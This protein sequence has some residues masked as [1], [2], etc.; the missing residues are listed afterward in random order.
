[1]EEKTLEAPIAGETQ[2]DSVDQVES[3]I[4]TATNI[5]LY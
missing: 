5:E 4:Q 1:M 2:G 3:R